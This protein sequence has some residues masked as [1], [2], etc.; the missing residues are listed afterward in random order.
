MPGRVGFELGMASRPSA[1]PRRTDDAPMRVLFCGDFSGRS[2]RGL[3][4]PTALAARPL[5]RVDVDNLDAVIARLAPAV[6]LSVSGEALT[7]SF[8]TM[9]DFHPDR[10][11]ERL[12]IFT[13]L[14]GLRRR[15]LEPASF[16]QARA[17]LLGAGA[18]SAGAALDD[19]MLR[20]L[21]RSATPMTVAAPPQAGSAGSAL[22]ALLRSIVAPDIVPSVGS[23][24]AQLVGV[25]DMAIAEQM[26]ALLHDPRFQAVEA[27]W[28]TVQFI[29]ARL[30]LDEDLQ[31]H[32]F[33]VTRPELDAAAADPDLERS[34]L[35][36]ALVE[37][38][39]DGAGGPGWSMVVAL[40]AFGLS[41]PD[42]SL[43][44]SLATVAAAAGAPL[45][46]TASPSLFGCNAL[47]L[48][49]DH[50]DWRPLDADSE[51]RWQALRHSVLAPWI[52]LVTPRMLL[53]LP[54]G[55]ATDPLEGFEFEEMT[56]AVPAQSLLWG[57]AGA[58]CAMLAGLGF[59]DSGWQMDLDV[60][61]DVENLPAWV[62]T[63]DDERRLY[64]CAEAWLGERAGQ[65]LLGRG[66]MPLLSRRDRPAVR[67]MRWQSIAEP[68]AA[69][70]GAWGA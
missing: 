5:L 68:A 57:H 41:R 16:E 43:L 38:Q 42:A 22:D 6:E 12:D 45:V 21:G 10:L 2:G 53:R 8:G 54:Y 31:L 29:A 30:E 11:F 56:G 64:P 36:K 17:E 65:E 13:H 34:G 67:L 69:L 20:L 26:R 24:Q 35:W 27:A 59:R 50:H 14:R 28:R 18:E 58:A 47:S 23:E 62:Y 61:L 39:R 25:V 66:L 63:A 52:G 51:S 49:P 48:T 19:T 7:I 1:A 3:N 55:K 37:R 32:L 60:Q 9:D 40:E 46:A 70:A 33:D 4:D 15:L 44:A